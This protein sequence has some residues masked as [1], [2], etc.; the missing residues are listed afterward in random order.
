MLPPADNMPGHF[1]LAH[2][3]YAQPFGKNEAEARSLSPYPL[4]RL[5]IT[6]FLFPGH[7]RQ[8]FPHQAWMPSNCL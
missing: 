4:Y 5:Q 2:A 6:R 7:M 3:D 1:G 8:H